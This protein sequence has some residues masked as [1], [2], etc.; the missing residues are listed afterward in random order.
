MRP[1][2]N[3]YT[4]GDRLKNLW[5]KDDFGPRFI[6]AARE[7]LPVLFGRLALLEEFYSHMA[8][9]NSDRTR[10]LHEQLQTYLGRATPDRRS[11]LRKLWAA[12]TGTSPLA[13]E[14]VGREEGT[15]N[16]ALS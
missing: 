1:R 3:P 7:E 13:Y 11:A 6:E 5:V 10:N 8:P 12:L 15:D 14:R 2:R 16:V 9:G 4:V